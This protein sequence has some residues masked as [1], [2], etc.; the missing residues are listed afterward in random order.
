MFIDPEGDKPQR[1][2]SVSTTIFDAERRQ[3]TVLFADLVD[4]TQL[5]EILGAEDYAEVLGA[6]HS[7]CNKVVRDGGGVVAQ[8]LGDGIV[9]YFGY[10]HASE[11]D[12]LRAVSTALI[13]LRKMATLRVPFGGARINTR[14]G[15]ATG[16]VIFGGD[17]AHFGDSAVGA[18]LNKAARL[19]GL[20][21]VDS[22]LICGDTRKLVGEHFEVESIGQHKLKGF[23]DAQDVY[24]LLKRRS[25]VENRFDALRSGRNTTL[26]GRKVELG[27]LLEKLESARKGCAQYT[28]VSGAAGLGKSKLVSVLRSHQEMR[29]SSTLML[30]CSPEHVTTAL[31]PVKT[32][33][34]SMAGISS[35]DEEEAHHEKL[36]SF[37]TSVWRADAEQL[38]LLLDLLS[39]LGSGKVQDERISVPFKRRM[40]FTCLSEMLLR[41]GESG[42]GLLFMVED[43]HWIDPSSA[44][45]LEFIKKQSEGLRVFI[46]ITSRPEA[47][48]HP[49][50]IDKSNLLQLTPLTSDEGEE[51]VLQSI[52]DISLAEEVVCSV[53]RKSE[54]IPL[55]IEEYVDVIHAAMEKGKVFDLDT[56]PL[57]M[58]SIIQGK[59]DELAPGARE[60]LQAASAIGSNFETETV[61]CIT[62][63]GNV[64]AQIAV[65]ELVQKNLAQY[66][67]SDPA[68]GRYSFSHALIRD[69]VYASM[70]RKPRQRLHANI[71]THL[72]QEKKNLVG[73]E[74]VADHLLKAGRLKEAAGRFHQAVM[75][76]V[77]AGNASEA[78]KH[79]QRGLSIIDNLSEGVER[80][81]LELLFR[82]VQA[83]TLMVTGGPGNREFGAMLEQTQTLMQR[84][85]SRENIVPVTYNVALHNW[86]IADMDSARQGADKLA[87]LG[88][89]E[90]SDAAFMSANTMQGVVAW[91]QGRN[92][93]A[94]DYLGQTI[95]QYDPQQHRDLYNVFL[96]EFGVFACF[97]MGL[98]ETVLGDFDAGA[99]WAKES[100]RIAEI[101]MR[102]HATGFSQLANFTTAMLRGDVSNADKFSQ[103]SFEFSTK[104]GFPEFIAMSTFCQG[105]V[106]CQ[107][108][109]SD[110][111]LAQMTD[112][113]E[114][115]DATGFRAWQP[116]FAGLQAPLL[117]QAG[118][119]SEADALLKKHEARV[120]HTAEYQALAPLLLSRA[121][122][123]AVKGDRS[124]A[125][126]YMEK[127][128]QAARAQGSSLWLLRHQELSDSI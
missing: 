86:A 13:L 83:P 98:T 49:R 122:F 84:L 127:A 120:A 55:F 19:E 29:S 73:D 125:L 41:S 95:E 48:F 109:D 54:G 97:Y 89:D 62:A 57:S 128:K 119:V 28:V 74:I 66:E 36:A 34:N 61:K 24:R 8:Y 45:L 88:K 69:A 18:C 58:G 110:R 76:S 70:H 112:G 17:K 42:D 92:K 50:F 80:D 82:T 64:S 72:S 2:G 59:L 113:A 21:D 124:L 22:A 15:I 39:P 81:R 117:I 10:P 38:D 115:W 67:G 71:A 78:L 6:Y 118:Y 77:S 65:T 85:S 114:A 63:L 96:K 20:A 25:G 103:E 93:Q 23:S 56:I 106:A 31:Y 121:Q 75:K 4:S 111:G 27:I 79:L 102:P 100:A 5:M 101:V 53:L 46:V 87:K 43:A 107:E 9:C 47:D 37:F 44:E 108:G 116:I 40:T 60:F 26:V 105:W 7:T 16:S 11:T 51:L 123:Y 104:Q 14:M 68:L 3:L 1:L 33:I 99:K 90:P 12:A 91:H 126:E 30:Q 94:K 52:P 32:Y 35:L